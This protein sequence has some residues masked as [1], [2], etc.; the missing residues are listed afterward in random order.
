MCV[1]G[2]WGKNATRMSKMALHNST[3][4]ITAVANKLKCEMFCTHFAVL[5]RDVT[6][7]PEPV[8]NRYKY[9]TV[10]IG[11]DVKLIVIGVSLYECMSEG[12]WLSLEKFRC[13]FLF[14][15]PLYN[16][17]L[18]S[19]HNRRAA[20][21]TAATKGTLYCLFHKCQSASHSALLPFLFRASVLCSILYFTVYCSY[22]TKVRPFCFCFKFRNYTI[23]FR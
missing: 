1:T 3:E 8:K 7:H 23:Q 14:I 19:V 4:S 22:Q 21:F 9:V 11:W 20:L 18:N 5:S 2:T 16:A 17:Y 12:N 10:Q 15:L 6:M 13:Y